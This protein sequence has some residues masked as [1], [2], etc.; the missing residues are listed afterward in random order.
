MDTV[1][2]LPRGRVLE[3]LLRNARQLVIPYLE[4]LILVWGETSQLFH[5]SLI[6]QVVF[7]LHSAI[8]YW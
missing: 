1:E 7:I 6:L 5:N 2:S 8:Q 4:H 3:W